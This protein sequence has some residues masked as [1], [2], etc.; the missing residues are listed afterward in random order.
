MRN[1]TSIS[2][3]ARSATLE[4]AAIQN[5]AALVAKVTVSGQSSQGTAGNDY[6]TGSSK[7]DKLYAGAGNDV[8]LGGAGNDELFG[9]AGNDTLNGGRG[10][11]ILN[12]GDGNDVLDGGEGSDVLS[13]GAGA[14]ILSGG[15][16]ND[17]LY[18]GDGNDVLLGGKGADYLEG[19]PDKTS[20]SVRKETTRSSVERTAAGSSMAG[21]GTIRFSFPV[22]PTRS[23]EARAPI[24]SIFR[25]LRRRWMQVV[26]SASTSIRTARS[27]SLGDW[28][29][30]LDIERFIGTSGSDQIDLAA[31]PRFLPEREMISSVSVP[32]PSSSMVG[33]GT[34]PIVC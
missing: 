24:R 25:A 1:A 14:D 15:D 20:F 34:I 3:A 4:A 9:G 6:L 21:Q 29:S 30:F 10:N 2:L 33:R 23:S 13:G 16:G 31:A 8:M 12:G 22:T 18:G 27:C 26:R 28:G 19:V 5:L 11:D 32:D 17:K 7:A